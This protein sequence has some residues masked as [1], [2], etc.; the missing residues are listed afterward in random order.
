MDMY[1]ITTLSLFFTEETSD[2]IQIYTSIEKYQKLQM[3][4][5]VIFGSHD[6]VQVHLENISG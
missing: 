6:L 4:L 2:Q 5:Y 3:W 1:K